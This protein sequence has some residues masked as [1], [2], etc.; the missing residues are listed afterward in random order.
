MKDESPSQ[1]AGRV[2]ISYR[3]EETAY[4]AISLFDRLADRFGRSQIFKDIDSIQLGDDFV[5]VI[6]TAVG[7]CDVLLALIGDQWL[8]I[9]DEQ[10]RARLDNPDDFVRLEIEAALNRNIRVIPILVEGARMP[11]PDQLP[12]SLAKLVRRNALELNPGHFDFD[13]SR[14][15]KVLDTTLA[16]ATQQ[17][18]LAK[19]YQRAV[20][21]E[22]AG[23]WTGAATAYAEILVVDPT[24]RDAAARREACQAR[25]RLLDLQ[26]EL[27]DHAAGGQW[28]AVLD[29][30]AKLGRLDP[31]A[32]DPDQLAT[33]A[34]RVLAE[35]RAQREAREAMQT[36]PDSSASV[37][38]ASAQFGFPVSIDVTPIQSDQPRIE[39]TIVGA[40]GPAP[41]PAP[42]PVPAPARG[43]RRH[44]PPSR[45]VWIAVLVALALVA[46]AALWVALKPKTSQLHRI[47]VGTQPQSVAISPDGRH[48]YVANAGEGTVSVINT[49]RNV[50]TNTIP[51]PDGAYGVVISADGTELYVPT[52]GHEVSVIDTRT[53]RL[54][55]RLPV[56]GPA[57]TISG[58]R[59]YGIG[60][61][62]GVLGVIDT[63]TKMIRSIRTGKK[64]V[65]GVAVGQDGGQVY[66]AST[67]ENT[68]YMIDTE[69]GVTKDISCVPGQAWGIAI[70]RDGHKLYVTANKGNAVYVIDATANV[71]VKKIALT[72]N[73]Q[74]VT[75]SPDGR[76]AYITTGGDKDV[77]VIDTGTDTLGST[78]SIGRSAFGMAITPDGHHAYVSNRAEDSVTVFAVK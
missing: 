15:L 47:A 13:T 42:T 60:F 48:A 24:Y 53:D 20:D 18:N 49:A 30:N 8:T 65:W 55:T 32:T 43:P 19:T 62:S 7:S 41:A 61:T 9:T 74:S 76:R 37:S 67:T 77:Y 72:K 78:I 35:E 69:T 1:A 70:T 3:R 16:D 45:R 33:H 10:G 56:A 2:F 27:R 44:R 73:A 5:E 12:P 28:Q 4:A 6:T 57:F 34:Q 26:G 75:L 21:A 54:V 23:E 36:S 11:R 46:A 31:S 71:C 58:N 52:F 51:V 64:G 14:L 63:S 50:V 29:V 59:A 39:A 40:S 22:A 66:A 25:Q 17:R 38:P 68:V